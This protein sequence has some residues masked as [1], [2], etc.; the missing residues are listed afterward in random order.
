M[1][2]KSVVDSLEPMN[3]NTQN[4][5]CKQLDHKRSN[6]IPFRQLHLEIAV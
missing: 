1:N 5:K 4:P 3:F 2:A 6:C